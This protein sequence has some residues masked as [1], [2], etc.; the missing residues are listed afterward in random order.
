LSTVGDYGP[1]PQASGDFRI[2]QEDVLHVSLLSDELWCE[3]GVKI[4][5]K[6]QNLLPG[7]IRVPVVE[8]IP[9]QPEHAQVETTIIFCSDSAQI[10]ERIDLLTRELSGIEFEHLL[11]YRM[12]DKYVSWIKS[13]D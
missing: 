11:L 4:L 9:G 2:Q 3:V 1:G 10:R 13:G 5:R 7:R 6:V 12:M 8:V